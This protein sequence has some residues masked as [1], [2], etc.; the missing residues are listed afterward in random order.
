M[1]LRMR[2]RRRR[3]WK[4]RREGEEG[5]AENKKEVKEEKG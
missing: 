4:R 2:K 1:I 3:R 5:V